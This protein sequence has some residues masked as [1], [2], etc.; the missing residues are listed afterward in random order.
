MLFFILEKS[1]TVQ[2]PK[3]VIFLK[4]S[5]KSDIFDIQRN[6]EP[7]ISKKSDIFE[8]F[9]ETSDILDIQRN[10]EPTISKKGYN[11]ENFKKKI[12]F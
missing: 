6:R 10:R 11:F 3:Q 12:F 9:Q 2:F 7:T 5:K 8:N 1:G 4:F